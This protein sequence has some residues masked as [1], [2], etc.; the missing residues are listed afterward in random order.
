MMIDDESESSLPVVD[1]KTSYIWLVVW[2]STSDWVVVVYRLET[3][4]NADPFDLILV[5][6]YVKKCIVSKIHVI[7]NNITVQLNSMVNSSSVIV[8]D[9]SNQL[10]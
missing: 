7:Q 9:I 1:V 4:G 10:F 6:L 2:S 3:S 8:S 5:A